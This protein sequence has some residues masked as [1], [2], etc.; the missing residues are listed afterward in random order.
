MV[1]SDTDY[2]LIQPK[3]QGKAEKKKKGRLPSPSHVAKVLVKAALADQRAA[4]TKPILEQT[5]DELE[6]WVRSTQAIV[7]E[8]MTTAPAAMVGE[9]NGQPVV[10]LALDLLEEQNVL[11]G[12]RVLVDTF[13]ECIDMM[14]KMKLSVFEVPGATAAFH[15][16]I[17]KFVIL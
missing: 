1:Y 6:V 14:Y 5:E 15:G 7:N 12:L 9:L 10:Q 2:D 3:R 17:G 13:I 4:N 16:L 11:T 8:I